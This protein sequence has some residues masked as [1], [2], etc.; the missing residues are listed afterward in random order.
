MGERKINVQI[1]GDTARLAVADFRQLLSPREQRAL[2]RFE[3]RCGV[4]GGT[5][6]RAAPLAVEKTGNAGDVPGYY[7][8]GHAAVYDRKSL[9]LGGFQEIVAAAAFKDVLDS[10]PLV[11]LNW[12]HDMGRALASTRSKTYLLELRE[13]PKG[14]HFYA[15]VAPTTAAKDLRILMEGG[16]I[17]QASFAFTVAEDTWEIR[18]QG[19]PDEIVVRTIMRVG[20]LFDVTVTAQGA[21]PQTDSQVVRSY[22]ISYAQATTSLTPR[23][24]PTRRS[25]PTRHAS[26]RHR[27]PFRCRRSPRTPISPLM[28]SWQTGRRTDGAQVETPEQPA[29]DANDS[30]PQVQ[31]D[32]GATE[33]LQPEGEDTPETPEDPL[34][35]ALRFEISQVHPGTPLPTGNQAMTVEEKR[36][37]WEMAVERL[38]DLGVQL[39]HLGI[40]PDPA[41]RDTL[42]ERF[43]EAKLEADKRREDY[44]RA[45]VIAS[46][47]SIASR[48]P[49]RKTAASVA[50]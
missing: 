46:V 10:D 40:N 39:E 15:K 12:D 8:R 31:Q 47:R 33:P 37:L 9:D 43:V 41:V 36:S 27:T 11:H 24:G 34:T 25:R 5:E 42:Q 17:D 48:P 35:R 2:E 20:E 16:V 7:V 28:A 30:A 50:R 4:F 18:N 19:K 21:Y 13:D 45:E 32:E 49:T 14:L 29:V 26:T 1:E 23:T 22:A 6:H 38:E 44:E 3:A